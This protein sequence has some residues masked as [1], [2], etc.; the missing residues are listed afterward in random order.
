MAP[1]GVRLEWMEI[2][3]IQR[4]ADLI[5]TRGRVDGERA[6][7]TTDTLWEKLSLY[8]T[9]GYQKPQTQKPKPSDIP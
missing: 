4:F 6:D 2:C 9:G 8:E 1:A 7:T 3:L 5:S